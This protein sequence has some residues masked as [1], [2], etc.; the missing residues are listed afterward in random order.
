MFERVVKSS[1]KAETSIRRSMKRPREAETSV[2]KQLESIKIEAAADET[3]SQVVDEPPMKENGRPKKDTEKSMKENEKPASVNI[4]PVAI[5]AEPKDEVS[6][7]IDDDDMDFSILEDDE[8]QFDLENTT[9]KQDE[10]MIKAKLKEKEDQNY[11]N[12][13]SQWN[14]INDDEDDLLSSINVDIVEQKSTINF[15]LWDAYEDPIKMP[16]KVFLFGR[17][18][19]ENNAKEFKSVCV[20]VENVDRN[21]YVLPRKYVSR[22]QSLFLTRK[23]ISERKLNFRH[24]K[25]HVSPFSA[26]FH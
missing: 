15:W 2:S 5:K 4:E 17:M 13:Q 6:M 16:G 18:P 1:L 21:M 26:K 19:M 8:N 25:T 12:V 22:E 10:S 9:Q 24:K 20:T 11:A 14:T 7:L 23:T 3:L